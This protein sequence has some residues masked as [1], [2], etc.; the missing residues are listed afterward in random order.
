MSKILIVSE[1]QKPDKK[2][3]EHLLN[4]Y[5]NRDIKYEIETYNTN[6]H[7]FYQKMK[8]E[9]G[10]DIEDVQ[11]IPI[12]KEKNSEFNFSKDDFSEIYLFF[13]YDIHHREFEGHDDC[14]ILNEQLR[15]MLN[16]FDDETGDRGKLYINY[17]MVESFFHI[18]LDNVNNFKEINIDLSEIKGYKSN[19]CLTKIKGQFVQNSSKFDL[20]KINLICKQHIMKENFIISND[21]TIPNYLIY[22]ASDQLIIFENQVTK[23][24]NIGKISVLSVFPR[25]I[26]DYFGEEVFN[27]IKRD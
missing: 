13:D 7:I 20:E 23:Y 17:P 8:A 22:R 5:K 15:E 14:K 3:I 25:F 12:L 18:S 27:L 9:Y 4:I 16:F 11:L 6:I 26:V 21:Y 2:I 19:S 10:D 24:V 1:G